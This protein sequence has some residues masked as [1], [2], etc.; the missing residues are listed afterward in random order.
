MERDRR[1]GSNK[2]SSSIA[3]KKERWLLTRKTWRYMSDAV[4][5]FLPS[6]HRPG[7]S[8]DQPPTQ[9]TGQSPECLH[10][11]ECPVVTRVQGFSECTTISESLDVTLD[12]EHWFTAACDKQ[13]HFLIWTGSGP[14]GIQSLS[15]HQQVNVQS[16]PSGNPTKST[17]CG[18]DDDDVSEC[19]DRDEYD[20]YEDEAVTQVRKSS[21][22]SSISSVISGLSFLRSHSC[23]PPQSPP[24]DGSQSG[25]WVRENKRVSVGVQTDPFPEETLNRLRRLHSSRDEL[26]F[27][28]GGSAGDGE[29]V[30]ESSVANSEKI[31]PIRSAHS[32][33]KDVACESDAKVMYESTS[34]GYSSCAPPLTSSASQPLSTSRSAKKDEDSAYSASISDT[35]MRY[36]RMVRKNSKVD[37]SDMDRFKT[38]N[39][40]PSLR[41]IKSKNVTVEEALEHEKK[42]AQGLLPTTQ[43]ET[44]PHPPPPP[45]LEKPNRTRDSG[46]VPM[47]EKIEGE[48]RR[49]VLPSVGIQAG[50][51]LVRFLK[52]FHRRKVAE[53]L[54]SPSYC[55]SH[56]PTELASPRGSV[57]TT[58]MS[59]SG[60]DNLESVSRRGGGSS[61]RAS[62]DTNF[63]P[64]DEYDDVFTPAH[65]QHLSRLPHVPQSASWKRKRDVETLQTTDRRK[66]QSQSSSKYQQP[67][68]NTSRVI[69]GRGTDVRSRARWKE[70]EEWTVPST[71][72]SYLSPSSSPSHFGARVGE[73][74]WNSD[75]PRPPSYSSSSSP[76]LPPPPPASDNELTQGQGRWLGSELS[77]L[78]S[79]AGSGQG[80]G[81]KLV[82]SPLSVMQKSKSSSSVLHQPSSSS[83]SASGNYSSQTAK[84]ISK[85]KLWRSKKPAGPNQARATSTWTP[86]GQSGIWTSL[87]S[88][89]QVILESTNVRRLSAEECTALQKVALA[90]LSSM[91]LGVDIKIPRPDK[92]SGAS[93]GTSKPKR[94]PYL[95]KKKALSTGFFDSKRE[96][97]NKEVASGLVFNIPLQQCLRNDRE[98]RKAADSVEGSPAVPSSSPLSRQP[99]HSSRLSVSSDQTNKDKQIPSAGS[100]ESLLWTE[101]PQMFP[102]DPD[103]PHHPPPDEDSE[104]GQVPDLVVACVK[105]LE[106]F[107]L[108][109]TGIFRVSSSLKRTR[110]LREEMDGGK[111]I[112]LGEEHSP[113]DVAALLKEFLRDL[114]EP[115][116]CRELYEAFLRTQKI[117]NRKVQLE[118]VQSLIQLLPVPNRDTL[119]A[120]LALFAKVVDNCQDTRTRT[121]E[122]IQGNKMEAY[123]LATLIAPN[124]L[125]C[126]PLDSNVGS[127]E[128]N[129]ILTRERRDSIDVVNYLIT[130]YKQLFILPPDTLN[131]VY[132]ELLDTNPEAVESILRTKFPAACQQCDDPADP[133]ENV[134]EAT[135][136]SSDDAPKVLLRKREEI[137]HEGGG[138]GGTGLKGSV[139]HLNV[140]T[141]DLRT[142]SGRCRGGVDAGSREKIDGG[143]D[144]DS[145]STKSTSRWFR[146]SRS[147]EQKSRASSDSGSEK[148]KAGGRKKKDGMDE[149]KRASSLDSVNL[150]RELGRTSKL[151]E[152]RTAVGP[153]ESR[154]Q[155]KDRQRSSSDQ[156]LKIPLDLNRRQSSPLLETSTKTSSEEGG[157]GGGVT[158]GV[159]KASLKIQM[160]LNIDDTDIPFIEEDN[161][162]EAQAYIASSVSEPGNSPMTD[163]LCSTFPYEEIE[164][165]IC[166]GVCPTKDPGNSSCAQVSNKVSTITGRLSGANQSTSHSAWP[167]PT[168]PPA[169]ISS[170]SFNA[171]VS[172]QTAHSSSASRRDGAVLEG[173]SSSRTT[174]PSHNLTRIDV[175]SYAQEPKGHGKE[176]KGANIGGLIKSKTADFEKLA[177]KSGDSTPHR[178]RVIKDRGEQESPVEPKLVTSFI[179]STA[180][181]SSSS[182]LG[183][184]RR[185]KEPTVIAM[186]KSSIDL[187][188][189]S[190]PAG[191]T[192][193]RSEIIASPASKKP[194]TFL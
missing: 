43:T 60:S 194:E 96:E 57:A 137:V 182:P 159:I 177:T 26:L 55:S 142:D 190:S 66:G 63:D 18:Q 139:S 192:W 187:A 173:V 84:L 33:T 88:G 8:S 70:D 29:R 193:K 56:S 124:I 46:D 90:K 166:L 101:R 39:Y 85:S 59:S 114:P 138:K 178:V 117:R 179:T 176:T 162:S 94:R 9:I 161:S 149:C 163:D 132:L 95:L 184:R 157:G 64:L 115:L 140:Y 167:S 92:T 104:W 130:N 34:S 89:R 79:S 183:T 61:A 17:S 102:A 136:F 151:Q 148:V 129:A 174:L 13:D 122:L 20:E 109:T 189:S 185:G 49:K 107:G 170:N 154:A 188:T 5:N 134:F 160:P 164:A 16:V 54:S 99:H 145:S 91:N 175:R 22:A 10:G 158:G 118:C 75:S 181:A 21:L 30:E 106:S 98:R 47:S 128:Q 110:Q 15:L 53:D 50:E 2:S 38:V 97:L 45:P 24:P 172:P 113:H 36:L 52:L 51:S 153:T 186:S 108:H 112:V 19:Y 100:A 35:V 165:R 42:R 69:H 48:G 72:P 65:H 152:T 86:Q 71:S 87:L 135:E 103:L 23:L 146:K 78:G 1:K 123:S 68:R 144:S 155:S 169:S 81:T 74:P 6:D 171:E 41:N 125:P 4:G 31:T 116:L 44:S 76:P 82:S 168:R 12:A 7:T 131:Q 133:T 27:G 37:K 120:L 11:Q 111:E 77:C 80:T 14:P 191:P 150:M 3:V 121:G 25:G 40:D 58:Q 156:G 147:G 105:H 83:S 93:P 119:H 180:A 143:A 127:A 126:M 28:P 67:D 141:T 32:V 73:A 62:F